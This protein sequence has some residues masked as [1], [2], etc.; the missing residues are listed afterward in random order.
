MKK[1]LILATLAALPL[2]ACGGG[3]G[4]ESGGGGQD[5][6]AVAAGKAAFV[7][8]TCA[9]CHGETGLGD[10]PAGGALPVKPRDYSDAAWQD[11][12]SDADMKS[13]ITKGGEANGLS[14]LMAAYPQIPEEELDQIVA[15]IRSLRK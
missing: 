15:F 10:G 4:T 1:L 9:T 11:S 2:A 13:V 7:K 14:N 6:E 12:I 3:G 8:Y 5:A